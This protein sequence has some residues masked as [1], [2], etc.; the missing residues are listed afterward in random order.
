MMGAGDTRNMWSDMA[1]K[2]NKDCLE[3]HLVGLLNT[4]VFDCFIN[5]C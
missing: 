1:V 4:L 3:L 2:E 5:I